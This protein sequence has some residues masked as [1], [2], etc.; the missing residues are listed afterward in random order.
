MG[1]NNIFNRVINH[2][3]TGN[4]QITFLGAIY[5]SIMFLNFAFNRHL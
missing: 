1:N 4:G 5:N 3:K 2:W